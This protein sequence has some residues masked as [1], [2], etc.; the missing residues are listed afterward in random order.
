M[1]VNVVQQLAELAALRLTH[2]APQQLVARALVL[3]NA[4]HLGLHAHLV[5]YA[6]QEG[7]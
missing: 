1:G 6:T 5:Q 3:P 4:P 2:V 7:A